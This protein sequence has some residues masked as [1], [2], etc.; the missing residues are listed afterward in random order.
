MSD[1]PANAGQS[2]TVEIPVSDY[3]LLRD[4]GQV[5]I[6]PLVPADRAAVQRFY[7]ELSPESRQMRFHSAG[8]RVEGALLDLVMGGHALVAESAGEILGIATYAPLRDRTRAEMAIAIGDRHQRRGIG[9]VLFERL[10]RDA[11]R[12][13]FRRL[14]A[15]VMASNGR[16]LSLLRGLG[17]RIT[18]RLDEGDVEV[19]V[20]L[21]PD[22]AYLARAD[23]RRHV[24]ATA[25]L[26]P[27]IHARSVAV[28]GASRRRGT[29]GH[30]LFRNLLLGGFDGP[31][32][33]VN[34]FATSVAGV[35]VYPNVAA[36]PDPV[37]LAVIV[38]PFQQVIDVAR[39][40]L[41]SGVRAM[42]VISAGFAEVDEAGRHRQDELLELC[43]AHGVRL[44]GPN[45]MGILVN[46]P[47]GT[48]NATFA[49]I[50]PPRGSVAL[51]S[52][53]GAL[54]IAVLEQARQLGIGISSFVSMGNKADLSSNDLIEF[55][56]D[57]EATRIILLYLESFGA[58]RRFG[59]IARRV[60][61]R[62]PI[63][64]VKGGRGQSGQRA[65]ASHT[66]A[67]A[68][69]DVAVD[70]LFRQAGV[71]RCDTLEELFD[72]TTLF[73]SQPLPAG[74]RVGVI[75]NA[76]G[77]GIL[78]ADACEANGLSLPVLSEETRRAL[79][80][81]LPVEASVGNPVD[82]LASSP[83]ATYGAVLRLVLADPGIDA[84]IVLFIPPLVTEADDVAHALV[85]A[86]D[87]SVRKPVLTCF[88]G[89]Q[90]TPAA[91]QGSVS[92]P[93]YR[94]PEA[95]AR[96]LGHAATYAEWLRRPAGEIPL[97]PK[98]AADVARASVEQALAR[99]DRSWLNAK[100]MESVLR[101]Y[102][103]PLPESA[104]ARSADEAAS[105]AERMTGPLAIKL[106]SSTILHKTDVDGVH[107]NVATPVAARDAYLAIEQSLRQRGLL[108]AMD[109]AQIQPMV[110]GGV[111]C[112]IG[113]VTDPMFGPLIAFGL[114]GVLAEA[115]GDVAFR[116]H[117]LT[118][119]DAEEL[120][121]SVKVYKLLNGYRGSPIADFTALRELLLRVSQMVEDLPEIMELDL[122]PVL[123][124]SAGQGVVA[125]DARMRV[126][127]TS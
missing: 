49:P 113:V 44:V 105:I 46:G 66:A 74:G 63:I 98:I 94:F 107:L 96:A 115:L 5:L 7:A 84:V 67:L 51:A 45:C 85:E 127:A 116:V 86:C 104:I 65:A 21:R 77:L 120:I 60:G 82:M 39:E 121:R 93:S 30:E 13:G 3:S 56:E 47:H 32:Y 55:W 88:V 12:K 125:L 22:P 112:L 103:I 71:V 95:A 99:G 78:C 92:I 6:R 80:D 81:I 16:I 110:T 101:A 102:G 38:V 14:L 118:D 19:D 37:D 89:S 122:N 9:T 91:L 50:L 31:V 8:L 48:M 54:G 43:R 41:E 117:P 123:V 108:G 36:I 70:A 126:T 73:A 111:E 20:E 27:L 42:V 26:E 52:Q 109:G 2:P 58:A 79:R 114:G 97:F 76:G 124:R 17:F 11:R 4:G 33:P 23:A 24:A 1:D 72:V 100:E 35:R 61:A 83:A 90:G 59:R 25:S 10:S 69:S 75:T 68:G 87:P 40:S 18:R 53:S 15:I 106:V 64:A 34:P 29:I 57:D 119:I 28:I 62:K